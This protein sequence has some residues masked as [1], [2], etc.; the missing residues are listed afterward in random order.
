MCNNKSFTPVQ[1]I[2]KIT[3]WRVLKAQLCIR[4]IRSI[5]SHSRDELKYESWPR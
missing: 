1:I 5:N 3:E 4:S 2:I